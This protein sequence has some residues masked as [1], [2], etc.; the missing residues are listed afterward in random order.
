MPAEKFVS[1][2]INLMPR[3][4]MESKPGGKFLQW[5]LS[6]GKKI[7]VL[8]ELVV[9]LAFLSR[10]KIDAD[11]AYLSDEIDQ[12]KQIVQSTSTFEKEFRS[13]SDRVTKTGAL[14][15]VTS[16]LTVYQAAQDLIPTTVE[17]TQITVTGEEVRFNGNGNDVALAQMVDA[18]KSS[19]RFKG[20]VLDSIV[21]EGSRDTANF[22]LNASYVESNTP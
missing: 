21:K 15:D 7:V 20:I 11:V 13:F 3:D 5:A 16:L 18:F 14:E 9:V 19:P 22:S 12:K 8:T 10:F 17:V 1:P 6:W 2:E 4:D